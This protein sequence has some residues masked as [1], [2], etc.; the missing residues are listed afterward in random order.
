M[1]ERE[2]LMDCKNCFERERVMEDRIKREDAI[3]AE[4]N[5][6]PNM[7]QDECEAVFKDIPAVE[8]KRGRWRLT[9]T[10]KTNSVPEH[11]LRCSACG[12]YRVIKIGEAFPDW[13]ENCG[14]DMRMENDHE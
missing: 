3:K 1:A 10:V 8:P 5:K 12:N 14:A 7:S 4:W 6:H 11:W 13:C 9:R 2:R